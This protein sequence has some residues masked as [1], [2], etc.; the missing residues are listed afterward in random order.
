MR[1]RI[2]AVVCLLMSFLAGLAEGAILL[3]RV[4]AI[5]NKDVITWSEV[6]KTMEFEASGTL[7]TLTEKDRR[8]FLRQNE[9][10]FLEVL[11]DLRLQIQEAARLGVSVSEEDVNRAVQGIREKYS[12]SEQSFEESIKKEGFTMKEY[13]RKVADQI[14]VGRVVEQEVR[15]KII[16]TEGDLDRYVRDNPQVV[17]DGEG[18][19]ISHI[20]LKKGQDRTKTEERA[21]EI[22][23]KLKAGEPFADVASRY[24]EDSSAK[25]GGDLGFIRKRDITAEFERVLSGMSVGDISEPFWTERG[26]HILKLNEARKFNTPQELRESVRQR[27]LEEKFQSDYKNWVKGLR[28]K[29]YVEIK[30]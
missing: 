9:T 13:R 22:Y 12:M 19:A 11:I 3:D 21:A 27:L 8:E 2:A 7:K 18:Y 28:Q 4:M 24:S 26:M 25:S 15:G 5:V 16:V 14:M 23:L 6:Y 29:A 17:R 1:L 10:A 30:S 20:F